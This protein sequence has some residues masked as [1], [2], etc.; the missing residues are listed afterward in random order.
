MTFEKA[1]DDGNGNA[2]CCLQELP[3]QFLCLVMSLRLKVA[4]AKVFYYFAVMSWN[5]DVM[6][7]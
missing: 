1:L 3:M 6:I 7:A 2:L 5:Q 4:V